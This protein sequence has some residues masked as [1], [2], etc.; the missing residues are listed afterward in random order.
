[1][2][3]GKFDRFWRTYLKGMVELEGNLDCVMRRCKG[4]FLA[5][6][7]QLSNPWLFVRKEKLP[8]RLS[9]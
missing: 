8:S 2:G 1:V 7:Y 5:L 9:G 4:S 6:I 3:D